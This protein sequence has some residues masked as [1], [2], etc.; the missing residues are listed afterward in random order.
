MASFFKSSSMASVLD[1]PSVLR[2]GIPNRP[3]RVPLSQ[4]RYGFE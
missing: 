3:I 1:A 4:V 2:N